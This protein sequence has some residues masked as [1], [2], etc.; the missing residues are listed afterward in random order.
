M[1]LHKNLTIAG[2]PYDILGDDVRLNLF[3]PGRA[4]FIVKHDQ[5]LNGIVKYSCG[6]DAKNIKSWFVGYIQISTKVD[7]K[8]QRIFCRELSA[9][10]EP[11]L[12]LSLRDV[13]LSD[14]LTKIADETK[15][16][17][18]IPEE[19]KSYTHRRA[20]RFYNLSGGYFALDSLAG[21]FGVERH[22][23]QQQADGR[24]FV[25]D[26]NDSHWASKP[27]TL[28]N[29]FESDVQVISG[30]TLP[31]FPPLRPGALYNGNII[32][33]VEFS[34]LRMKLT[35]SDNPWVDLK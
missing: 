18:V 28:P 12:P 31:A 30:A 29:S 35:W 3:T 16:S 34:G 20:A 4:S 32:T 15:L 23:W 19:P 13:T 27:V 10:L 11:R 5:S 25:G 8:Q 21:V 33:S 22:I 26:W 7:A 24:I 9:M 17:F 6:Y 1:K 2:K 14:V